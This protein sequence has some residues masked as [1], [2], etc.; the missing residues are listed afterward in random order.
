M[1]KHFY[2][3][4]YDAILNEETLLFRYL[5]YYIF[6]RISILFSWKREVLYTSEVW[7]LYGKIQHV[8]D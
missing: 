5:G 8:V 3:S 4:N 6:E 2:F 1:K 7:T